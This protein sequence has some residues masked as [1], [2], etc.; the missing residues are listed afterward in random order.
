MKLDTIRAW[1]IPTY[2]HTYV[3]TYNNVVHG[4]AG[5]GVVLLT[6]SFSFCVVHAPPRKVVRGNITPLTSLRS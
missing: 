5:E 6:D 1:C 4:H 2:I 3:C